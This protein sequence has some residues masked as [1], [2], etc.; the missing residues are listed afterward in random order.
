[1]A[2]A[3]DEALNQFLGW[4]FRAAAGFAIDFDGQGTDTFGALTMASC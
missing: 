2:R 4:P 3:L 1:L